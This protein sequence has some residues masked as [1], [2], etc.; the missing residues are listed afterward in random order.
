MLIGLVRTNSNQKQLPQRGGINSTGL[1]SDFKKERRKMNGQAESF[2]SE[3]QRFSSSAG[4]PLSA[5]VLVPLGTTLALDSGLCH[6]L[7]SG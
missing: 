1:L 4:G 7:I 6:H 2:C 5:P 3:F